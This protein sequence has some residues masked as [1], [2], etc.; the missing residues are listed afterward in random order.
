MFS[1]LADLK[2]KRRKTPWLCGL[3]ITLGLSGLA[4]NAWAQEDA[5]IDLADANGAAAES[6]ETPPTKSPVNTDPLA[7]AIF[8]RPFVVGGQRASLGGYAETRVLYGVEE[9]ISDGVSFNFQRFN[10]FA[11]APIGSRIRFLSE[12]EFEFED[13]ELEMKLETAQLDI[14]LAPEF[15]IRG[16]IIL[17]PVGAFNQSHDGPIWDFNDR[18]LVSTTVMPSTFSEVGAG[19]NGVIALGAIELDYQLYLTQGLGDGVV[20]NNM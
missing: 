20:D 19:A 10:L 5:E 7:N 12:L 4:S 16:G 18:P 2:M 8:D 11:F 1:Q 6:H 17:P 14:E 9:G 15:V 3:I 13:G